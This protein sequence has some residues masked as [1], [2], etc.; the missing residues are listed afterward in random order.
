MEPGTLQ[1]LR[2]SLQGRFEG[3]TAEDK[4][5][6]PEKE[7]ETAGGHVSFRGRGQAGPEAA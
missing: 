2:C 5:G 1:H 7:M 3:G 4:D 6:Q